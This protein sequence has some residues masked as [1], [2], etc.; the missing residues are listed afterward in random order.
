[1]LWLID[2]WFSRLTIL[3]PKYVQMS[4]ACQ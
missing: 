3:L 4:N 2:V 1:M